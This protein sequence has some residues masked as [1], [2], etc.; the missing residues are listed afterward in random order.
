MTTWRPA[1]AAES[2]KILR[3]ARLPRIVIW[4]GQNLPPLFRRL[5]A[6]RYL[7]EAVEDDAPSA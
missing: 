7:V 2:A 1:I 5:P 6:G 4:N 3:M